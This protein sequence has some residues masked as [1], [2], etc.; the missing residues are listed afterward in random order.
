MNRSI[1][2]HDR[3][4]SRHQRCRCAFSLVE[5]LASLMLVSIVLPVAMHAISLSA[6]NS[7]LAAQRPEAAALAQMKLNELSIT[8]DYQDG[9]QEGD[10]GDEWPA[11]RWQAQT[12]EWS[13]L[14]LV[15]V[16]TTVTWI[17]RGQEHDVSVSTVVFDDR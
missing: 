8:G 11:Y 16:D 15:Q 4:P 14:T 17:H 12:L 10:F 2:G 9:M 7:S 3:P 1:N 5:V 13:G 6:A